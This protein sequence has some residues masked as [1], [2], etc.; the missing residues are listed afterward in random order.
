MNSRSRCV[1]QTVPRPIGA[2][3]RTSPVGLVVPS[4]SSVSAVCSLV[5]TSVAVR[6]RISPCSVST[7]PRA[8]RWNSATPS[9]FSS[10]ETCRLTA[11][12]LMR[13][14]SPACVKLPASAAAWKM[15]SLSQSI[16]KFPASGTLA[17]NAAPGPAWRGQRQRQGDDETET[18]PQLQRV[19]VCPC[20][21]ARVSPIA[22][23]ARGCQR[24]SWS[25]G[26]DGHRWPPPRHGG[27]ARCQRLR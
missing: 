5:I 2:V 3:I 9:S 13:N 26:A 27:I 23:K 11:D 10:A 20:C 1:T 14:P 6:N 16:P 15:R 25:A 4:D 19:L 24:Q 12:W 7:S 22:A 18:S 17:R 8:W 21:S